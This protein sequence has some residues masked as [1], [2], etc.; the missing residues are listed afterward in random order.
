MFEFVHISAFFLE[1][2]I[3]ST[4]N[5]LLAVSDTRLPCRWTFGDC[6]VLE[7]LLKYECLRCLYRPRT[8]TFHLLPIIKEKRFR[9][10]DRQSSESRSSCVSSSTAPVPQEEADGGVLG[11]WGMRNEMSH[12]AGSRKTPAL[13]LNVSA[14]DSCVAQC[15]L[16]VISCER[17]AA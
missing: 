7:H 16:Y 15:M 9:L 13:R 8:T 3:N 10:Q 11:T 17:M 14:S 2:T 6:R 5:C 12:T 1:C 4:L